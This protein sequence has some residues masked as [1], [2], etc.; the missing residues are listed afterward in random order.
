MRAPKAASRLA[1]AQPMAPLPPV[2]T[3]TCP[4]NL[5]TGSKLMVCFHSNFRFL[6]KFLVKE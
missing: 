6:A 1:V 5:D 4:S 3:A 2:M